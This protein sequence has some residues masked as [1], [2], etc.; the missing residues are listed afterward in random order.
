MSCS[1]YDWNLHNLSCFWLSLWAAPH[2]TAHT[3]A[4][5]F[6]VFCFSVGSQVDFSSPLDTWNKWISVFLYLSPDSSCPAIQIPW[7]TEFTLFILN[8]CEESLPYSHIRPQ[9]TKILLKL[10]SA[11]TSNIQAKANTKKMGGSIKMSR[12]IT[13]VVAQ[14]F[15]FAVLNVSCKRFLVSKKRKTFFAPDWEYSF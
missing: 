2:C 3:M 1:M 4:L 13:E 6:F 12:T 8:S 15:I 14:I 10:R 11:I 9:D 7:M 5:I